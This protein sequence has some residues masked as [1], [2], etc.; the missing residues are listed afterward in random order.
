M[1]TI[2]KSAVM[3]GMWPACAGLERRCSAVAGAWPAGSARRR[4]LPGQRRGWRGGG[5]RN[6]SNSYYYGDGGYYD[7]PYAYAPA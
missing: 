1:N 5:E 2:L 4:A 6:A 7:D 3:A